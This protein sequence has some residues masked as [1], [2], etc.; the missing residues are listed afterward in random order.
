[1][2]AAALMSQ[3]AL[4]LSQSSPRKSQL[5]KSP[6]PN[7]HTCPWLVNP[8]EH[9]PSSASLPSD[10]GPLL[11]MPVMSHSSEEAHSSGKAFAGRGPRP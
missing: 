3:Q 2:S 6:G 1:M 7:L 10:V 8:E 5:P 4:Q 11:V 9:E